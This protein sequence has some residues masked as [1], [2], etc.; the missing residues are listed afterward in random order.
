M[1]AHLFQLPR[2]RRVLSVASTR[3]ARVL[4]LSI[5]LVAIGAGQALARTYYVA[6][7]GSGSSCP[8]NS[9]SAPFATVQAALTCALNGDVVSLAPSGAT[10]YPGIGPVSHS[11]TIKAGSGNAQ[12]VEID[13]SQP[14]DPSGTSTGLM[15]VPTTAT[16]SLQGVTVE[17]P[18]SS[19]SV[20]C[21]GSLIENNGTL[22]LSSVV[23]TGANHGAAIND[24]STGSTPA[25]L[26]VTNSTISDN[27]NDGLG[28]DG[29]EA[30]GISVSYATGATATPQATIANTTIAGNTDSAGS[31]AGGIYIHAPAPGALKL[32]NATIT[33]NSGGPTSG[34]LF[35]QTPNSTGAPVIASNTLIAGNTSTNSTSNGAPDCSGQIADGP[36]GHNL[37]G[38]GHNCTGLS[39]ATNGDLVGVPSPGLEP[40]AANGGPAQTVALQALS[41]AIGAAD[42]ATCVAAPVSGRDER[43]DARAGGVHNCD[44][45]AYDTDGR[46]GSMTG[47]TWYVAPSG[48]GS[49]CAV[50]SPS[51]PFETVQAALACASDGDVVS[52]APSGATPYPG[53][54]PVSHSVTIKAGL[55]NAQSVKIDVSQ[56]LDSSGH[57]AGLMTVPTTA[58][59]RLQAVTVQCPTSSQGFQCFGS[60]VTN[61]GTLSLS[62]VV[63]TGA[64]HGAAI[65]D[66]STGSTPA[67]LTVNNSTISGNTNDGL[68]NDGS[69]AAG[70]SVSYV[71][72]TPANPTADPQATIVNTTIA[73][74]PGTETDQAAGGIYAD[75]LTP[76]AVNLI[77]DTITHNSGASDGGLDV[78]VAPA[79]GAAVIASNTV[80]AGNTMASG[81]GPDCSGKIADGAGGH[82]LIGNN[83]SCTGLTNATNGDQVGSSASPIDPRLGAL[84][85]NGGFTETAPPLTNSPL[86]GTGGAGTCETAPVSGLDQRG[87][88]RVATSRNACDIGAADTGGATVTDA[89]PA[90]TSGAS[91]NVVESTR[92]AVT[93]HSS[94]VPTAALSESGALPAGVSFTDNGNGTATISG[95]PGSSSLGSYPVTITADNGVEPAASQAFTVYVLAPVFATSISPSTL[96]QGATGAVGTLSGNGFT[97]PVKVSISGPGAG[98]SAGVSTIASTAVGLR[99]TVAPGAPTGSYTVKVFNGNGA[100][101]TCVGCLSVDA[102][103]TIS[104]ISPATVA[105]GQTTQFT[106]TGTGFSPDAKLSGPAGTSFSAVSV[107]SAGTQITAT[108]RVSSTD[109]AESNLPV[110]VT[111]GAAGNHG[112]VKDDG[113]TVS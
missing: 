20:A 16:V 103:P 64:T 37:I 69:E 38:N 70:I 22:S 87:D 8:A 39:N 107:N 43:G 7:S 21:L 6:P 108:L 18:T 88:S 55:G 73:D 81:T 83:T 9:S 47:H 5:L 94:G 102:G 23:V 1:I 44:I 93:V 30:A 82:N 71:P 54:G 25:R 85:L 34:G 80:I 49:S 17:C 104:G 36:G 96:A 77:N 29:S 3:L 65:N 48:S 58:T 113:L 74:N 60:L 91:V 19:Q 32:I 92:L 76:G 27:T 53:I 110:V 90:I 75:T 2:P 28:N 52:L 56:P 72:G 40:L 100:T 24:L 46:G 97:A 12:S 59:V 89:A 13:V 10:P 35:D 41:P 105:P 45:G 66:L 98:V 63:V 112:S 111:D 14:L 68:G 42:P 26:T 78:S 67:R 15:S 31:A 86:I 4:A 33:A 109:T 101:A 106:V 61:H 62:G 79:R 51:A 84:A 99:I 57:S 95:T 11:V 50:N